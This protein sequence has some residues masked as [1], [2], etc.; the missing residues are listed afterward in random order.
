[1]GTGA[2]EAA[3]GSLAGWAGAATGGGDVS[4]GGDGATG[5]IP[6]GEVAAALGASVGGAF[7]GT[8]LITSV[9]TTAAVGGGTAVDVVTGSFASVMGTSC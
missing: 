2:A 8:W 1:M 6:T 4:A 5:G 7:S 9:L 3:T